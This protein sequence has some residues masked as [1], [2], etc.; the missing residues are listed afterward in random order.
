MGRA[1]ASLPVTAILVAIAG[2]LAMGRALAG[3]S[4]SPPMGTPLTS[5]PTL[6]ALVEAAL[7]A[8][9]EIAAAR[10]QI[11]A[12]L[13]RAPQSRALPDPTL[14]L[15]IQNDGFESIQVGKMASSWVYIVASQTF[16]W[17]GKR[18]LREGV[19]TLDARGADTDLQR[20]LLGVAADVERAY[21][22]LL[23]VRGQL[24]L[25]D[26]L[27]A[28]WQQAETAARARYEAGE[29]AQSDFLRAQLEKQ[30]LR[31]RRWSLAADES[32]RVAALDRLR[33][34]P[35]DEPIPTDRGLVDVPDPELPDADHAV[36]EALARSPEVRRARLAGDQ[37]DRRVDLARRERWP[38]LTVSAGVMPRGGQFDTMWQAGVALNVPVWSLDRQAKVVAENQARGQSARSTALALSQLLEQRVRERCLALRVVLES[39]HLYRTGLLVQSEATVKS[40][41]VQYQVGRVTFASV[42]EALSGY[43]AD[44]NGYLESIAAG[45][46]LAIALRELS[47]EA[48]A[49]AGDGTTSSNVPGAGDMAATT[50]T[51]RAA[52]PDSAATAGAGSGAAMSRM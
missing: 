7:A 42:L 1:I 21:V 8:R 38:D 46:R 32:R 2:P 10:A 13:A 19:V 18:G 39:N 36:A 51:A 50:S 29:G 20:Q 9:P 48:P 49:G 26:R 23:L 15:G 44:V 28:L 17:P 27:D 31:Q 22:D 43:L 24:G 40:T 14:A 4:E 5:D 41:L 11:A 47:L 30:R 33:G 45:Q 12:A 16:P 25:L 52:T 35:M 6:R 34:R 3:E 37:A